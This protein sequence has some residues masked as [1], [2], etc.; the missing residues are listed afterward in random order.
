[1]ILLESMAQSSLVLHGIYLL[2]RD[3]GSV[4]KYRTLFT[5]AQVEWHSP[6]MPGDT[7]TINSELLTWRKMRIRSK[8]KVTIGDDRL[9][10]SGVLGG[11]GVKI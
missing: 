6:V 5:D 11:I 3:G 7:I 1:V 4:D 8:V 9:G 2:H 10:A